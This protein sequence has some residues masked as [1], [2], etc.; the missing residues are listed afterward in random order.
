M[1]LKLKFWGEREPVEVFR[2]YL[3]E[4]FLAIVSQAKDSDKGGCHAFAT[5][6]VTVE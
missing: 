6:E 5:I 2:R 3:D 1:K 4:N